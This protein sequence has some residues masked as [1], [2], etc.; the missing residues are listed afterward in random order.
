MDLRFTV[1]ILR[2]GGAFIAYVP[3]LDVSTCGDNE[4]EARRNIAEA[5]RGF[6]ETAQ[7]QGT[8]NE[9]LQEAGVRS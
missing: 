6:L 7:E 9:I 5:V 2:E 1:R 3:E 4:A 8:L